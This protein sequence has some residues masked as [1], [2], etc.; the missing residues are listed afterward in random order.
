LRERS[1]PTVEPQ[2]RMAVAGLSLPTAD[3]HGTELFEVGFEL[4]QGEILGL[5]GVS[6]NGQQELMAALVGERTVASQ[7]VIIDGRPAGNLSVRA[8]RRLGL[9]Y[10]PEERQ[11]K[12]AVPELSLVDNALLTRWPQV[13]SWGWLRLGQAHAMAEALCGRHQVRQAGVNQPAASLSGGNLQKFIMGRELDE[14]PEIFIVAQPTWGV[15]VAAA[16]R[17]QD[18]LLALRERGSALLVISDDL[19]ELLLLSDR[20]AVMSGGRVSPTRPVEAVS[21]AELGQWMGGSRDGWEVF[22]DAA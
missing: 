16:R 19:D 14:N 20:I 6:G 1:R 22:G 21:R 10:V 15:D 9:R 12:G 17:I 2:V 13:L 5:A 7:A 11:G 4:R 18:G 3:P 8:R